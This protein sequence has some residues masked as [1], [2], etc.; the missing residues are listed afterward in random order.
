MPSASTDPELGTQKWM[1]PI[2]HTTLK[3]VQV[4]LIKRFQGVGESWGLN[5]ILLT[6]KWA[7]LA[8]TQRGLR[9]GLEGKTLLYWFGDFYKHHSYLSKRAHRSWGRLW[10]QFSEDGIFKRAHLSLVI[11]LNCGVGEKGES[12][13]CPLNGLS[14]LQSSSLR[15]RK[16]CGIHLVCSSYQGKN[17]IYGIP[18]KWT[19]DLTLKRGMKFIPLSVP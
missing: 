17:P 13:A 5:R 2:Q 10:G 8:M 14:F 6:S 11:A 4:Y 1:I 16:E 15:A 3:Y 12:S 9:Y 18:D 19:W 7:L